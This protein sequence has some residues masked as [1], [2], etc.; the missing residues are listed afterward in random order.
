MIGIEHLLILSDTVLWDFLKWLVFGQGRYLGVRLTPHPLSGEPYTQIQHL[1]AEL[2][3]APRHPTDHVLGIL[4]LIRHD[5][6][7]IQGAVLVAQVAQYMS[8]RQIALS[9][10][11]EDSNPEE[12]YQ[13][14]YDALQRSIAKSASKDRSTYGHEDH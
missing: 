9:R 12:V 11:S 10:T 6:T 14:Q 3:V 5:E 13:I 2:V 8:A 7:S 1:V 4:P